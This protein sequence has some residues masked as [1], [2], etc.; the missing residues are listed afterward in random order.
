MLAVRVERDDFLARAHDVAGQA[1]AQVQRVQ[2]NFAPKGG[3]PGRFCAA[4]KSSRSSSSE[5]ARSVFA[6]GSSPTCR[7]S[8]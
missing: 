3:P 5:W 7:S 6:A 8:H 1:A 2:Q 4:A